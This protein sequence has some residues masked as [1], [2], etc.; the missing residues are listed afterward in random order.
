MFNKIKNKI[1]EG[2]DGA[3]S[4]AIE[5]A[6]KDTIGKYGNVQNFNIDTKSHTIN[7][8]IQ[9]LGDRKLLKF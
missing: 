9:L 1:Q 8:Q 4:I 3:L 2:K 5:T 6:L 7:A